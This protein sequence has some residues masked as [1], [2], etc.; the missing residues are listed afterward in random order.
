MLRLYTITLLLLLLQPWASI[1]W[2]A[3]QV[4]V[5]IKPI[6]SLVANI[7]VGVASPTLL[8]KQGGSPHGYAMRPSEARALHQADLVIWV[9]PEMESFL[10]KALA[11]GNRRQLQ[12]AAAM[13]ELLHPARS[14]G[15]WQKQEHNHHHD[16]D[17]T[18]VREFDP[19]IWLGLA[20][21]KR[22]GTSTVAAL[23]EIDPDNRERYQ[24]NGEALLE[25]LTQLQAEL[26]QQ[27]A[28]VA[29]IPYI[30]FHDAYQY[31]ENSFSLN[32]VGSVAIDPERRPG[33]RR[34]LE[35][36]RRIKDLGARCVFSEPQFEP[37]LVATVIEGTGASTATLD[38]VGAD[39]PAG[40]NAYFD[41]MR[42]MSKAL[43]AGLARGEEAKTNGKEAGNAASV[44]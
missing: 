4:V 5:S 22:I 28:P 14:G 44:F 25:R 2:A 18:Q 11:S 37:R 31:F 40:P 8:V 41:L 39:L 19:H 29:H 21:A 34:V 1:C 35:I 38:P 12:L 13:P 6:H 42:R 16:N 27:L 15:Q 24:V 3:P 7:M 36:R 33:L 30:V 17:D 26:E 10:E 23:S 43:A 32:A 20:Q 9:G